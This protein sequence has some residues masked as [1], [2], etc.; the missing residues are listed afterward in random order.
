MTIIKQI[1]ILANSIK[2]NPGRCV[3]GRELISE[4]GTVGQLGAWIRPISLDGEG[5]LYSRHCQI[6]GGGTIN[7][8]DIFD[9]PL[10]NHAAD[11]TQ[12][13]NWFIDEHTLWQR[14][15]TWPSTRLVSF[16]ENTQALWSE[17]YGRADRISQGFI[18]L[19]PPLQSLCIIPLNNATIIKD[20]WDEKKYR[21]QFRHAN[22][23]YALKITDPFFQIQRKVNADKPPS[24]ACVSLA[25]PF[26]GFHY[27]L[28][29]SLFW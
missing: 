17:P 25:P 9:V 24:A 29:A 5:E 8:F 11:P 22:T 3:A 16:F 18:E 4:L 23:D 13:E 7:L 26:Q 19:N 27:K 21:L 20:S 6:S 15:G 10:L 14:I 28:I 12:P 1:V 2:H